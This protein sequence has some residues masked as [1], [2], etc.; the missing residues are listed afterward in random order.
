[1]SSEYEFVIKLTVKADDKIQALEIVKNYLGEVELSA[2]AE[3]DM[4][5]ELGVSYD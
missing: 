1:M 2:S 3:S 4:F 5:A